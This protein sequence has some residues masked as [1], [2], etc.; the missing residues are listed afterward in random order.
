M[1]GKSKDV[2]LKKCPVCG[3][4]EIRINPACLSK[5]WLIECINC[6][7]HTRFYTK[8]KE[9]VKAWNNKLIFSYP[10]NKQH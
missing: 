5:E 10:K 8:Q 1:Q 3:S 9:A 2:K 6:F 4:H 7:T